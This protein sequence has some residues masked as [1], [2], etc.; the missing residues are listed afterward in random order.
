M[1][2]EKVLSTINKYNLIEDGDKIVLGISGGPDSICLLHILNRLKE[3]MDIEIYAA[4]L[5]HQI[6]GLEAQKDALYVS[7]ICDNMGITLFVKSLNVPKYCS[8][9][10]LSIEEGARKLRYEMFDE[11]KS[12]IKANKIA[13]GH[14]LNDQAETILMRIMRGTGLQGLRGIEYIRENSIIRPI[15]D[16]DRK[17]IED[18]CKHYDLKPRIDK[19]NLDNIYTRNKIRLELIPYMKDNFNPNVIESIVRMSNSLK[20]DSDYIE[21]ESNIKYNEV[22]IKDKDSVNI[23]I[24]KYI[25]LHKAIKTRILRKAISD[26]FG[27][28]NFID[29]KHIEDIM[30]LENESKL[31]K[32][33]TLPRRMFA[34]RTKN[35][36][37]LTTREIINE[38]IEF[39]YNIPIN[40]FVKI[41]ELDLIIETQTM[42][43]DRYKSMKSD[44]SSKVFDFNKVKGG[45]IARSRDQGDK[46][47]LSIGSKKIKQLFIDLKIPKEERCKIPIIADSE[48]I[49]CVG[50]QRISENYKIDI[51]T[52]E[53][54]KV[55]FKKL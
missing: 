34:Y 29:Q 33:I 54:L 49:M 13:V 17:D 28:T 16:I 15:L 48:E 55:S 4:H 11:I 36:I 19:S 12:K 20:S 39:C 53:V 32:K 23:D 37:I 2:F 9:N 3:K 5:N 21:C 52:K 7:K 27:D 38:D 51:N 47:K 8:D 43:I 44:K 35:N 46:I 22:S 26:L 25:S 24:K 50:N 10:G 42:S 6:R 31:D 40:G 1:I 30:E 45:I 41:K 18:Y 14:N